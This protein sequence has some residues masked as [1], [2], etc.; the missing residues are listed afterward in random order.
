MA[1][2][3]RGGTQRLDLAPKNARFNSRINEG[4]Q[5]GDIIN[6]PRKIKG[7]SNVTKRSN[8]LNVSRPGR[9]K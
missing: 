8:D 4:Q 6:P 7:W 5:N 9:E 3:P 1:R 2:N